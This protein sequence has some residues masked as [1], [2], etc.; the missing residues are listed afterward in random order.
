M[1]GVGIDGDGG[2]EE[3]TA[4]NGAT[5]VQAVPDEGCSG[6]V[7]ADQRLTHDRSQ[8]LLVSGGRYLIR[9]IGPSD[10]ELWRRTVAV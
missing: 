10:R 8:R 1:I 6:A 7:P 3:I 5:L 9:G 4:P 2:T